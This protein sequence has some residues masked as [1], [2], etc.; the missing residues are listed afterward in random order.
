MSYAQLSDMQAR[1]PNRD[2][3]QISNEDPTVTTVNASF[4]QT[5]LNDASAEID[6]Y[7]ESRFAL[8]LTDPPAPLT[9]ICCDLAMYRMQALRPLHDL[10]DARKRYEDAIAMLARVAAG[11]LTLGLAADGKE[12]A[13]PT[14]PAVAVAQSG[15]DPAGT[16]PTRLFSRGGLK[17]F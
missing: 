16:L 11:E 15:G 3:V 14:A 10:E 5:A 9:R 12:P 6:T 2:L 4:I 17:N 1:Y 13:D 7:L 8:P